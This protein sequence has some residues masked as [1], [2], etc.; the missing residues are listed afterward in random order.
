MLCGR[1]RWRA[2][3]LVVLTAALMIPG[4]RSASATRNVATGVKAYQATVSSNSAAVVATYGLSYRSANHSV[5]ITTSGPFSWSQNRGELTVSTVA[6]GSTAGSSMVMTTQEVIDG[7]RTYSS[8]STADAPPD[9]AS[10]GGWTE[11]TWRGRMTGNALP[12]VD[13][14]IL[15][16]GPP[17]GAPNPKAIL[18]LLRSKAASDEKLGTAVLNGVETTRFRS[19]I[20]FSQLGVTGKDTAQIQRAL[21]TRFLQIDYWTD[22]A[23]RLR[24]MQ[25]RMKVRRPP[26]T[27]TTTGPGF[28]ASAS[29]FPVTVEIQLQLSDYGTPVSVTPPPASEITSRTSCVASANSFTC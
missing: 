25:L 26:E 7:N 14:G 19:H 6:S 17:G 27:T 13:L 18:G 11:T 22:S 28:V 16:F 29:L 10:S 12:L 24:L 9:L 15:G 1:A 20:P 23:D 3:A 4:V 21:G 8:T 2:V 5:S